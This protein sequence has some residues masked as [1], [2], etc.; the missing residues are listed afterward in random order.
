MMMFLASQDAARRLEIEE[1][2]KDREV[3]SNERANER[4]VPVIYYYSNKI[5]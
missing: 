1:R 4:E 5:I 3:E 2:R